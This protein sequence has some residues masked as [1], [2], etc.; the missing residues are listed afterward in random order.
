LPLLWDG[1]VHDVDLFLPAA[2]AEPRLADE[3]THDVVLFL[4]AVRA[5]F[6]PDEHTH[7]ADPLFPDRQ[8]VALWAL[9]AAGIAATA[10]TAA[11]TATRKNFLI[12]TGLS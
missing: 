6:L 3:Q 7:V 10:T 12:V 8:V 11:I 4:W 9:E 5:D 1:H 2:R